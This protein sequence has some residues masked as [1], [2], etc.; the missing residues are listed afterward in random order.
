MTRDHVRR[1]FFEDWVEF[2]LPIIQPLAH[3]A[4]GGYRGNSQTGGEKQVVSKRVY[5]FKI[6]LPQTQ[7]PDHGFGDFAMRNLGMGMIGKKDGIETFSQSG[8]VQQR[9]D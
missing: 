8:S 1:F 9:A 2:P 7:Q 6:H 4:F 5:G 3:R